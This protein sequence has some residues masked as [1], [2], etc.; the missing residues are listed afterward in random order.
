MKRIILVFIYSA[1]LCSVFL[2]G[3]MLLRGQ[4]SNSAARGNGAPTTAPAVSV[5]PLPASESRFNGSVPSNDLP[6]QT[7]SLTLEDAVQRGLRQ[8]LG[9]VLGN[10]DVRVALAQQLQA[11]SALLPS[12]TARVADTEQQ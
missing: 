3:S 8:N 7:L 1:F 2:G 9:I 6:A 5:P 4:A 10:Q 12:V 11:R